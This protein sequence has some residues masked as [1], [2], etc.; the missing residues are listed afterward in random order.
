MGE[1]WQYE[2]DVNSRYSDGKLKEF[3]ATVKVKSSRTGRYLHFSGTD[4][5]PQ[6]RPRV[7]QG[8]ATS[9]FMY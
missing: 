9:L 3:P 4:M 8:D 1:I 7:Y 2:Y 6:G 5:T